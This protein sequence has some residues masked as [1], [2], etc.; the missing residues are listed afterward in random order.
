VRV[1]LV[2]PGRLGGHLVFREGILP[3]E[4]RAPS[5]FPL[6]FRLRDAGLRR[7]SVEG[8]AKRTFLAD[9]PELDLRVYFEVG[10]GSAD[11]T[12]PY[13]DPT[14]PWF[15]VFLGSYEVRVARDWPRPFGFLDSA[16]S[17]PNLEAIA[18]LGMA[19]WGW[20][21]SYMAGC[22]PPAAFAGRVNVEPLQLGVSLD[23]GRT[24]W[25]AAT[26]VVRGVP[27]PVPAHWRS[28]LVPV[29]RAAFAGGSRWG[30][31]AAGSLPA[32]DMTVFLFARAYASRAHW[33]TI[34]SGGSVSHLVAAPERE[35]RLEQQ[36]AGILGHIER[37][38]G[39]S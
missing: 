25:Q 7:F 22:R 29:W 3:G 11:G 38:W 16:A 28:P 15:N 20:L 31:G 34:V 10:R 30:D 19:D 6:R 32:V 9:A 24:R 33:H 39:R 5:P 26:F 36:R 35:Q 23:I 2:R 37:A 18:R 27:A 1:A 17:Q 12:A 13:A 21:S 8:L 14:S 4:T